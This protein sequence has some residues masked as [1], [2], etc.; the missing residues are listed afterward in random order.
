M[1]IDTTM[2]Y[3]FTTIRMAIINKSSNNKCWWGC[4][5]RVTLLCCWWECRLVQ[6]LW[7]AVCS[8]LKNGT[9]LWLSNSTS[10]NISKETQTLIRKSLCS[11]MFIVALTTIAAIWKQPK[12]PSGWVDKKGAVHLHNT[13]APSK[14]KKVLP[15]ATAWTDL[16]SFMQSEISQS[17]KD[18][19]HKI[20]LVCE[21]KWTK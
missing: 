20:L 10:G 3:H 14:K 8:Y 6:P 12:R 18:K 7:K 21:I 9:A 19:H 17:E 15:F 5:Q 13:T 11:P 1:Q 2:R 4:K 16:E